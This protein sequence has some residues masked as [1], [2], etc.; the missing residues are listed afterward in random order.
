LGRY[1][2]IAAFPIE[3]I[4][5][6]EGNSF[7]ITAVGERRASAANPFDIAKERLR[8]HKE[9]FQRPQG[10]DMPFYGGMAGLFGYDL[11]RRLEKIPVRSRHD[12]SFPDMAIG[13]YT[14]VIGFDHQEQKAQ[15][16]I[17]ATTAAEAKARFTAMTKRPRTENTPPTVRPQT[18]KWKQDRT[19]QKYLADLKKV[20][21]H[22]YAGDIFQTNL[23]RR[24]QTKRPSN[25]NAFHHYQ[26]LRLTSPA[27][28]AAFMQLGNIQIGSASPERFLS[29]RDGL[30]ETR[31][32]K[33]TAPRH[34]QP[35]KDKKA[36]QDL[37]NSEKD[38]AENIMI[39]DLLRND[40]AKNCTDPSVRVDA[41]NRLESYSNVH[42]LVSVVSGTLRG[43]RCAT[44]LLRDCFPGGS[45]TG[46]PKP[47]AMHI[48]ETL[49]PFRRGPYCGS[50][51]YIGFDGAMDSNILIRTVLY[52][53][54]K[55]V[56]NVGGGIVADSVPAAELQETLDKASGILASFEAYS[57][58][59]PPAK[60]QRRGG[61]KP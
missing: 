59:Q 15:A 49:E 30:V 61:E 17:F 57:A 39:V 58:A 21:D 3:T 27:P 32:I 40:L 12:L 45:I 18:V 20:I 11:G 26:T 33:G 54:D 37:L 53:M 60:R 43:D 19:R 5:T 9:H 41:L 52:D 34:V 56:F 31:P 23:T 14:N 1:S 28:F 25:F 50:I 42:H 46:A 8:H 44:D 16:V 48:I 13:L 51:G 24:F 4:E 35:D 22:I 6:Y 47:R 10:Y 55:I 36:A 2:F 38:R 7:T 29:L